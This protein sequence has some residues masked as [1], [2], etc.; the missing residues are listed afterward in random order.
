[1]SAKSSLTPNEIEQILRL[2]QERNQRTPKCARCRNHGEVSALKG[3]KR[4]CQWK[5]C[6]C[7]KCTLIAE[8]QRVMAAQV[9]LRRQQSQEEK[10]AKELEQ[11]FGEHAHELLN[12]IRHR[13]GSSD[14]G[15]CTHQLSEKDE[16][17]VFKIFVERR[18]FHRP[19]MTRIPSRTLVY[20]S[21]KFH[22]PS[23]V[24]ITS[25]NAELKEEMSHVSP[26]FV[27]RLNEP[28]FHG[29]YFAPCEKSLVIFR[30]KGPDETFLF[31]F[32]KAD[33]KFLKSHPDPPSCN[34][35]SQDESLRRS[36]GHSNT[37]WI[38]EE[39]S[40]KELSESLF[41][42]WNSHKQKPN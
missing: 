38:D 42:E 10:E 32:F 14:S 25:G 6:L 24:V 39:L 26:I 1:M 3:H 12:T 2:R 37:T 19:C 33:E 20:I 21:L 41:Q 17:K 15:V 4:F 23:I 5:D 18:F 30:P 36:I 27:P 35:N 8:R 28:T 22:E 29:P 13:E 9:A 34:Y 40:I 31:A 11:I 16:G 7:A